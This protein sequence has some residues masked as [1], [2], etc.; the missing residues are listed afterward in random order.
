MART[1]LIDMGGGVGCARVVTERRGIKGGTWYVGSLQCRQGNDDEALSD[2][3][4]WQ[5]QL[6]G[7]KLLSST[8]NA[9]YR[10]C[11][12]ILGR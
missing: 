6:L 8:C 11:R 9:N 12:A 4:R 10:L 1:S 5:Q 2:G 3:R 7:R